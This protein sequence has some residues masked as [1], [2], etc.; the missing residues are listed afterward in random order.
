MPSVDIVSRVN[1]QEV[2]NAVNNTRK[3][4][5]TRYDFRNTR[6]EITLDRK[7]KTIHMLTAD[8][9]KM[10]ALRDMFL[11]NAVRR[12]LNM[13]SFK[14]ED[15]EPAGLSTFKREVNIREGIETEVARKI[16]KLIKSTKLKVQA[17]IQGDQVRVTGKKIDD[18]QTIMSMLREE[19]LDVP[20]QFV[21]M[22]R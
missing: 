21:N 6:T 10:A 15:P 18:L 13:K 9:M 22:L 11:S 5:A 7:T 8:E 20:L 4:I 12:K 14:F 3:E 19:E 1:M 16:V 2:D 17:A